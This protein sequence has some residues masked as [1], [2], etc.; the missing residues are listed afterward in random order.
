MDS[1]QKA[2]GKITIGS[3][4]GNGYTDSSKF[5]VGEG[6]GNYTIVVSSDSASSICFIFW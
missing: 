5:F 1:F 4:R 6:P 2:L 3:L